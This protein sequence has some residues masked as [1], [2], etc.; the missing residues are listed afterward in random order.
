MIFTFQA[1]RAS[2]APF[3]ADKT[4]G[5]FPMLLMNLQ[6]GKIHPTGGIVA[7]VV[8]K[9]L[10]LQENGIYTMDISSYTSKPD[11]SGKTY[12]NYSHRIIANLTDTIAAAGANIVAQQIFGNLANQSYVET[13]QLNNPIQQSVDDF[14][15]TVVEESVLETADPF[16]GSND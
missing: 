1:V 5:I 6:T 3:I 16:E 11:A 10:K 14:A 7:D 12:K 9:R 4:T 13:P 8:A 2:G 15:E